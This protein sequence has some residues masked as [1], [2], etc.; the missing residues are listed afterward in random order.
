MPKSTHYSQFKRRWIP[1]ILMTGRNDIIFRYFQGSPVFSWI[2]RISNKTHLPIERNIRG[3]AFQ[4]VD[5]H[6][7]KLCSHYGCIHTHYHQL[8][9]S[10]HNLFLYVHVPSLYLSVCLYVHKLAIPSSKLL[11]FLSLTCS[12][13]AQSVCRNNCRQIRQARSTKTNGAMKNNAATEM[14]ILDI[15]ILAKYCYK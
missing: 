7:F 2:P 5:D 1:N 11:T 8:Y 4:W 3:N 6:F 10:S 9:V 15:P 12:G 13:N 14:E